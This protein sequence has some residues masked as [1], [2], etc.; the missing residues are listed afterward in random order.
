MLRC[1][2]CDAGLA[3]GQQF[4]GSCGSATGSSFEPPTRSAPFAP[5]HVA[6]RAETTQGDGRN[7][8]GTMIG[9]RYRIVALVGRG[10]MGEVYRADD[11]K[12]GQ[13]VALKFLPPDLERDAAR[14]ARLLEEVRIARQI[15]HPNVCRVHDV[16]EADGRHFLSMEFIDGENLASLLRRIGRLPP[17]KALQIARQL[18]AGLAAAHDQS[19]LH[20]DIKPANVM[21]D[22][23]GRARLTD[24]GL[25]GAQEAIATRDI[26]SGT[27]A[28]MAPEQLAGREVT[29]R[30]DIYALGL[31]LYETLVGK[32]AFGTAQS[33]AELRQQR[34]GGPPTPSSH[35]EGLDPGVERAI[36]RCLDPDPSLRPAS[37][38]AVALAL[39]GGDTLA[40]ALAAGETPAPEQVA[41]ASAQGRLGSLPTAAALL[42]T[43]AL[44]ASCIFVATLTMN[45]VP[46]ERAPAGLADRARDLLARVGHAQRP[47]DR[48][49]G[50]RVDENVWRRLHDEPSR[51]LVE[52]VLAGRAPIVRFWYRESASYLGPRVGD[53]V[54]RDDPPL[55]SADGTL[56]EMATDGR[57][58]S[59]RA[60][61]PP[62]DAAGE[63]AAQPDWSPV[64]EAAG[65]QEG[66]LQPATPSSI[67]PGFADVRVAWRIDRA[68][69]SGEPRLAEGAALAG[70]P[71]FFEVTFGGQSES[72]QSALARRSRIFFVLLAVLFC[73]VFAAGLWLARANLMNG[74]GDRKGALRIAT[75]VLAAELVRWT[76]SA[77]HAPHFEEFLAFFRAVAWALFEAAVIWV[78][79]VALEPWLR[80]TQPAGLVSW[81][82]LL[83]GR[84]RDPLVGRD[85]LLGALAGAVFISVV[86]ATDYWLW[87]S[88]ANPA[89]VPSGLDNLIGA[90]GLVRA[91]GRALVI[92]FVQ[93]MGYLVLLQ[94]FSWALR[95]RLLGACALWTLMTFGLSVANGVGWVTIPV[96]VAGA[97]CVLTVSRLGLL[98]AVTLFWVFHIAIFFPATVDPSAWHAGESVV[99]FALQVLPA[100]WGAWVALAARPQ[101]IPSH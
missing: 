41:A 91:A 94:L 93:A 80:R 32:P 27:P 35:V 82:R 9:G 37:A 56:V 2:K 55:D 61:L 28:Y 98:P 38:A 53:R 21:V 36:L 58:L 18:C 95:S 4:C 16:G 26:R 25:A 15:S 88:G 1:S 11:L 101:A 34:S 30:S 10:G 77:S 70:L 23:R 31:V 17:E 90:R 22:G 74:R 79:Y 39:P 42:A 45:H 24:F 68:A 7:L 71:V 47:V 46:F 92:S 69:S 8:P 64:L 3:E 72:S 100:A 14:L 96:G 81:A 97:V 59:M 51:E 76:L 43:L 6:S 54:L 66:T 73:S 83:A 63:A 99:A 60:A 33:L 78:L 13:P 67:P 44:A 50:Y 75:V 49:W 12:L 65:L 20:R 57:L 89:P 86:T 19:V 87:A 52:A 29:V 84:M 62:G 5:V 48:A 85:L 40:A